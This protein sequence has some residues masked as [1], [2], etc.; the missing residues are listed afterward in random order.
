MGGNTS[1]TVS[2]AV[3]TQTIAGSIA[4]SSPSSI[5]KAGAG[6]LVLSGANSYT[7]GTNVNAGTLRLPDRALPGS[8]A[9]VNSNAVL[10]YNDSGNLTQPTFTYT[11]AGILRKTGAGKLIFGGQGNVNVSFSTGAL[12]D[13]Q[14]GT[15]VGTSSFQG[16]WANNRASVNIAGGAAFDAVE[17]GPVGALQ[18]DALTGAG[19]FTGG[20][21]GAF[22][23][24]TVATIGIADGGGTFSGSIGDDAGA[25]LEIIKAGSGT[26]TFTGSD[27]YS[28]GTIISGG[29]LV[30]GAGNSLP[31]SSNVTNNASLVVDANSTAGSISGSGTTTIGAGNLLQ[32]GSYS[33]SLTLQLGGSS[34]AAN[35]KL[36]TTGLLFESGTLTVTLA[37]GFKPAAG[38]NF[39]LL[40]WG[41]QNG[42]Y[43]SVQLPLLGGGLSWDASQL[44]V[45][46]TISVGGVLGDYNHNGRVDAADYTLWRDTLGSTTNLAADGNANGVIDDG[47]YD[48]W[49]MH[50][51]EQVN[52]SGAASR[53]GSTAPEP[54]SSILAA[55]AGFFL[56]FL[57]RR[58]QM[59]PRRRS[60]AS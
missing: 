49:K 29:T 19:T 14:Q 35:A 25:H 12:I 24:T 3:A 51:G 11:G 54:D 4:E 30:I 7:G 9:G 40:D 44:N 34:A 26:E 50:F 43:S 48:V 60:P 33:G 38:D 23:A 55:T 22:G 56:V 45:N 36:K 5:A 18:F 2:S 32:A 10:E 59:A 21:F 58:P 20:Y 46:G 17:G 41:V 6:T 31:A 15:L 1:F 37:N 16:V 27:S 57:V 28:G 42:A 52:G 39:D 13:V 53:E 47:D 8:I